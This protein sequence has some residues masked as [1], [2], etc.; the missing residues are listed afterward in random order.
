MIQQ[1]TP[2]RL[3]LD[4]RLRRH[5]RKVIDSARNQLAHERLITRIP[6]HEARLD[7]AEHVLAIL[8]THR[9][10]EQREAK[11]LRKRLDEAER[12]LVMARIR[13]AGAEKAKKG[14]EK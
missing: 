5:L 4:D 12:D 3:T 1:T 10:I 11:R 8:D 7:L 14:G 6:R 13:E 2:P 9:R